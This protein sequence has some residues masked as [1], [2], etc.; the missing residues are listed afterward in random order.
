M[1]LNIIIIGLHR[2]VK[3]DDV[4]KF[5]LYRVEKCVKLCE[6]MS[7]QVSDI[8]SLIRVLNV[9]DFALTEGSSY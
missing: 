2:S 7:G 1:T 3:L 5:C 6:E 4:V 8:N 9:V